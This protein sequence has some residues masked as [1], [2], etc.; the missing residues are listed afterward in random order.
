MDSIKCTPQVK[1]TPGHFVRWQSSTASKGSGVLKKVAIGAGVAGGA[2]AGGMLVYAN[3]DP[4]FRNKVDEKIPGFAS[5]SDKASDVWVDMTDYFNPKPGDHKKKE[6]GKF[7]YEH[8]KAKIPQEELKKGLKKGQPAPAS[9]SK[10]EPSSKPLTGEKVVEKSVK[11]NEEGKKDTTESKVV[12]K[13][14]PKSGT[15]NESAGKKQTKEVESRGGETGTTPKELKQ[16]ELKSPTGTSDALKRDEVATD[17]S[18][19]H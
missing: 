18:D 16:D 14:E 7:V 13:D 1:F 19:I 11:K 3:Y 15:V 12:V 2:A 9:P 6:E 10:P 5:C 4:V 17:V 8:S